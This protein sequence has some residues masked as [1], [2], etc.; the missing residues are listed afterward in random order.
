[1]ITTPPHSTA[2]ALRWRSGAACRRTPAGTSP[3]GARAAAA[4][5]RT[6][7]VQQARSRPPVCDPARS[8]SR[9]R[10]AAARTTGQPPAPEIRL[11]RRIRPFAIPRDDTA[12]GGTAPH[13]TRHSPRRAPSSCVLRPRLAPCAGAAGPPRYGARLARRNAWHLE[14]PRTCG[15]GR[16]R[17]WR[18]QPARA[19]AGAGPQ[20]ACAAPRERGAALCCRQAARGNSCCCTESAATR[21]PAAVRVLTHARAPAAGD[22]GRLPPGG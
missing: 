19:G 3:P 15:A 22:S 11:R 20:L 10:A 1:M 8:A 7:G 16:H 17:A 13:A 21:S 2:H 9:W 4:R 5:T 6:S 18:G 12:T 14:L